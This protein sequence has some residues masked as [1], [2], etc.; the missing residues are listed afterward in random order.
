MNVGFRRG[1]VGD[2]GSIIEFQVAMAFETE[3][4]RLDREVCAKGVAE[5]YSNPYRGQYFVAEIFHESG[6]PVEA[7]IQS[8]I[9]ASLLII[10]EWSDWRNGEV[11]WIHSVYVKPQYRGKRIF[12]QLYQHVK[13]IVESRDDVRGLRLYVDKRNSSAQSVY[14]KLGMTNEHYDLYEW[15]KTF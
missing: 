13:S 4:I 5:V 2:V 6:S 3:G 10:P 7:D 8:E 14:H 15:M 1:M 9:V 11:W 12:S